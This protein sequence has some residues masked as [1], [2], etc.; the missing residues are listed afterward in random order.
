MRRKDSYGNVLR[1]GETQM[2]DGTYRYRWIDEN[3][4]WKISRADSLKELRNEIM[5]IHKYLDHGIPTEAMALTLDQLYQMWL[6]EKKCL[7][8]ARTLQRYTG[9][10]E[11]S[12]SRELGNSRVI[13]LRKADVRRYCE[14]LVRE[15]GLKESTV[16]NYYRLLY[17]ILEFGVRDGYLA[18]NPAKKAFRGNM[19][20]G[21]KQNRKERKSLTAEEQRMI[22]SA[23]SR[24]NDLK[25]WRPVIQFM[26]FTGMRIGEIEALRWEDVDFEKE[27]IRVHHTMG[28]KL[29]VKENEY[30]ERADGA[31]G[32]REILNINRYRKCLSL[33]KTASSERQI[34]MTRQVREALE[35]EGRRQ[36]IRKT[37][38]RERIDGYRDFVFLTDEGKLLTDSLMNEMI[39]QICARVRKD[40]PEAFEGMEKVTCHTFRHTFATRMCEAG[41]QMKVIQDVMGH[42]DIGM[43]M[44]VYA[45]ATVEH[46]YREI[47]RIE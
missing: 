10:Y 42:A 40:W 23:V 35:E 4:S 29:I 25:R 47:R 32:R 37:I 39:R 13:S 2:K 1:L 8:R 41:V 26:L 11:H 7:L 12:I 43:T 15:K 6:K 18:E 31:E 44:D 36:R 46:M 5:R 19:C 16:R 27:M 38:C 28:R 3:G 33:P 45:E 24:Y 17:Q 14:R 21:M 22:M 34:P 9:M 20:H 30:P